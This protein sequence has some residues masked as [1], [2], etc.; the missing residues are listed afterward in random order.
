MNNPSC[1]VVALKNPDKTLPTVVSIATNDANFDGHL[2]SFIFTCS[3]T[4]D[5][6]SLRTTDFTVTN[7]SVIGV[8]GFP[9]PSK[10]FTVT[11]AQNNDT[12]DGFATPTVSYTSGTLTDR[13]GNLLATFANMPS[14]DKIGPSIIKALGVGSTLTVTFSKPIYNGNQTSTF[15]LKDV[16]YYA[17][18]SKPNVIVAIV[19]ADGSD[20]TLSFSMVR[21]FDAADFAADMV[22]GAPT[23]FDVLGNP[24]NP[25]ARVAV[26]PGPTVTPPDSSALT[27]TQIILIGA[28]GGGGL[29]LLIVAAIVV[30]VL[31]KR[32]VECCKKEKAVKFDQNQIANEFDFGASGPGTEMTQSSK[33][34]ARLEA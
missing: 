10:M 27:D 28:V 23:I 18:S 25:N 15:L 19:D 17:N 31:K 29:F 21:A 16:V 24:L 13:Y 14:V 5:E 9:P 2:D 32:G 8:S 34:V 26:Q 20:S 22:G 6:T 4:I 33:G 7:Y 3:K 30:V 11:V 1:G 12:L